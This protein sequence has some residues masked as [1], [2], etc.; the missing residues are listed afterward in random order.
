MQYWEMCDFACTQETNLKIGGA[1][2]TATVRYID[3]NIFILESEV[4][5]QVRLHMQFHFAT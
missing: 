2:N 3:P 4:T 1:A 5:L